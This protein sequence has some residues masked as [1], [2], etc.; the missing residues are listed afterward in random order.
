MTPIM[1]PMIAVPANN[2]E[3]EYIFRPEYTFHP[4]TAADLPMLRNWLEEP[5]VAQWWGNPAEQFALVRGDLDDPG[6]EQFIV[7]IG[8]RPLAYLQCYD[9]RAWPDN[10]FGAQPAGTRGIDQ[11]IGEPDMIG[12]GHG[13]A[14]MRHFLER[15][16]GSGT[17][18]VVT[19]PD[20]ANRRAVRAYEK[21]GFKST[22]LVDTPDGRALLMVHD[23]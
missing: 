6:M 4:M 11:F 18:R 5:H 7:A 1:R 16:V 12:R 22:G 13:S 23:A 8:E 15:L 10:G 20:P 19:D 17:P 3:H 2:L 9:P 14:F 21:A